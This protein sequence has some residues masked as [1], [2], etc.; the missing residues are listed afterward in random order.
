MVW[1][2]R[3]GMGGM[4]CDGKEVKDGMGFNMMKIGIG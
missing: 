1:S 4:G 3:G 2:V